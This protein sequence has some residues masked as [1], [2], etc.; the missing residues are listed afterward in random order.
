MAIFR[1]IWTPPNHDGGGNVTAGWIC[2]ADVAITITA[3]GYYKSSSPPPNVRPLLYLDSDHTTPVFDGGLVDISAAPSG[4]VD[5]ALSITVPLSTSFVPAVNV[6]TANG[7]DYDPDDLASPIVSPDGHLTIPAGGGR[8][9]SSATPTFPASTWSGMHG[10]R[11]TYS[12]V[13][14]TTLT[15]SA[16]PATAVIAGASSSASV[17]TVS[18]LAATASI[19]AV[20]VVS[21]AEP[22][23]VTAS[24]NDRIVSTTQ[25]GRL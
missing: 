24:S 1:D 12:L 4:W 3:I 15:A 14:A 23:V 8:F 20:T 2:S 17:L 25:G 18:A 11:I 21:G 7:I 22:R 19:E 13:S 10:V 16:T 6:P 5:M 9:N